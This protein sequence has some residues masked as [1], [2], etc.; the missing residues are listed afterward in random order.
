MIR[1]KKT[2]PQPAKPAPTLARLPFS[3]YIFDFDG[4]I[5][6][7]LSVRTKAFLHIFRDHPKK[8]LD[9]FNKYHLASG[10]VSPV[11][12]IPYFY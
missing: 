2:E 10:G 8:A 1:R 5:L 11:V 6:D 7:A 9:E 12:K 3:A 4:V